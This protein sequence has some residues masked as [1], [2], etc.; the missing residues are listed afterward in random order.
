[1]AAP[2]PPLERISKS[3]SCGSSST[4]TF[5]LRHGPLGVERCRPSPAFT[6][7]SVTPAALMFVDMFPERNECGFRMPHGPAKTPR[8]PPG[9]FCVIG[10][11]V[12]IRT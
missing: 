8:V 5:E 11:A 12:L 4:D 3:H 10:R 1:M 2:R 9:W 7:I 6:A